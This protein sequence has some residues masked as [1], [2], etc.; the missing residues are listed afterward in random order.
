MKHFRAALLAAFVL[1]MSVDAVF[2]QNIPTLSLE[3]PQSG[4]VGAPANGAQNLTSVG[5]N[6][7]LLRERK[8]TWLSTD[9]GFQTVSIRIISSS[10]T[11][12]Q[13]TFPVAYSLEYFVIPSSSMATT[14]GAARYM[15]SSNNTDRLPNIGP[16]GAR[17]LPAPLNISPAPVFTPALPASVPIIINGL[18]GDLSPTLSGTT[19]VALQATDSG[20]TSTLSWEG[21][22][23]E[24][25]A[26]FR[27]RWSDQVYP[28]NPGYQG[29]RVAVFRL[30]PS[31]AT[32]PTYQLKSGADVVS[33]FLDDPQPVPPIIVNALRDIVIPKP[34]TQMSTTQ[35]IELESQRWRPDN[36]PGTVF[37]DDNYDIL[38]YTATSSDPT[39]VNATVITSNSPNTP[40]NSRLNI[41]VL[42]G[43]SPSTQAVI[44]VRASDGTVPNDAQRLST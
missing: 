2:G 1:C 36:V 37:Y 43:V 28:G 22:T 25:F 9:P 18:Q 44:T 8:Q 15:F 4:Q 38:T 3:I 41:T 17:Q 33:I 12:S 32:P 26:N 6:G 20:A 42:P 14:S 31:T 5:I 24:R 21:R 23:A 19:F 39:R 11:A 29:V 30:F 34:T 10:T 27:A 13:S 7:V 16:G 35:S 40:P